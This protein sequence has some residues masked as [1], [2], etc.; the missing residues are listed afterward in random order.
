MRILPTDALIVTDIQNDFCPGGSLAVPEGHKTVPIINQLLPRFEHTVYTRD[1]H[2]EGHCS[3]SDAP[4][5]TDGSWPVHCQAFS[6]GAEFNGDLHVPADALII[7]KGT[8]PNREAYSAFEGTD[9]ETHLRQ[10]GITRIFVCGLATDYCVKSTALDGKDLG[11]DV[12]II[13]NACRGVN[14]PPGSVSQAVETMAE[15]GVKICWSGDL[16]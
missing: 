12:F 15:A 13:E 14:Q 4:T 7:S 16:V 11:F 8:D 3:F 2:P 9:L 5:F 1:W 10:W 6:P